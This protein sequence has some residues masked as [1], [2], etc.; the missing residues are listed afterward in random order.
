MHH[1]AR[2]CRGKKPDSAF[3]N[4]CFAVSLR[5]KHRDGRDDEANE[6]TNSNLVPL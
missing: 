3:F 2:R 1:S 6:N 4:F 5:G